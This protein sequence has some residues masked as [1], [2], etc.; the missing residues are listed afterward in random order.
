MA[1]LNGVTTSVLAR[2]FCKSLG[3]GHHPEMN[4]IIL[5]FSPERNPRYLTHSLS[6]NQFPLEKYHQIRDTRPSFLQ[7][8]PVPDTSRMW[9]VLLKPKG[10]RILVAHFSHHIVL[11]WFFFFSRCASPAFSSPSL[12]GVTPTCR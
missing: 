10:K 9:E 3:T 4:T 5:M 6:V 1:E 11:F 12:P 8:P 7:M 2:C